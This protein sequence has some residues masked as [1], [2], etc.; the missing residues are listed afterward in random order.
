MQDTLRCHVSVLL[1]LYQAVLRL[2]ALCGFVY[3]HV[4]WSVHIYMYISVLSKFSMASVLCTYIVSK[5]NTNTTIYGIP[6]KVTLTG[7]LVSR[8]AGT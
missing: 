4:Y 8:H 7:L 2:F 1:P 3:I 5:Y 6:H